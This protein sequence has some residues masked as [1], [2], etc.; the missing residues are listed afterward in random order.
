MKVDTFLD[1][2]LPNNQKIHILG[3]INNI[4]ISNKPLVE[5]IWLPR[6]LISHSGVS[7]IR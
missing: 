2:D 1:A 5:F 7:V 6:G 4:P 3:D